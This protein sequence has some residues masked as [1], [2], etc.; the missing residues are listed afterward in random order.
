MNLEEILIGERL[1]DLAK[2]SIAQAN[3]DPEPTIDELMAASKRERHARIWLWDNAMDILA[4]AR[5]EF[6][7]LEAEQQQ[8]GLGA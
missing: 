7:R 4:A 3:A 1:V 8:K 6:A 2:R 5:R